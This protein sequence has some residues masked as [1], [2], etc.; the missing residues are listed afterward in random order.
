MK[1]DKILE[2][3]IAVGL[4]GGAIGGSVGFL[5]GHLVRAISSSVS[6]LAWGISCGLVPLISSIFIATGIKNKNYLLAAGGVIGACPI[7]VLLTNALGYN[8]SILQPVVGYIAGGTVLAIAAGVGFVAF[9]VLGLTYL[10][11]GNR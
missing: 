5:G 10:V 9:S 11:S 6:P 8:V 2:S 7:S 3:G 1:F 4:I